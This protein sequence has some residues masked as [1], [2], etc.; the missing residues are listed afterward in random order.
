MADVRLL[1]ELYNYMLC[2]STPVFE[3]LYLLVTFG[4]ELPPEAA[5]RLDPPDDFFRVR[6]VGGASRLRL[7]PLALEAGKAAMHTGRIVHQ[8]V[9]RAPLSARSGAWR[10]EGLHGFGVGAWVQTDGWDLWV[11]TRSRWEGGTRR[12][13]GVALQ[14]AGTAG[15]PLQVPAGGWGSGYGGAAGGGGLV[16]VV[17]LVV[18]LVVVL[19]VVIKQGKGV[20]SGQTPGRGQQGMD[21][22]A[23]RWST[24][25]CTGRWSRKTC[26]PWQRAMC[27]ASPLPVSQRRIAHLRCAFC[28]LLAP[29]I[30]NGPTFHVLLLAPRCAR[31]L[32][33]AGST[34]VRGRPGRAWTA[35]SPSSRWGPAGRVVTRCVIH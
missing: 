25:M 24:Q 9:L 21:G 8:C 12:G 26:G 31:C 22:L 34:S 15:R 29:P 23:Q 3:S 30:P 7:L 1:G 5:D 33:R 28:L 10:G 16:L 19:V 35:S 32:T 17:R 20:K 11:G 18:R 27:P 2:N 14:A 4:H 13:I 6:L